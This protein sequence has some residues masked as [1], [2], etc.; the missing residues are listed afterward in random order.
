MKPKNIKIKGTY[1]R[2]MKKITSFLIL[3]IF[4]IAFAPFVNATLPDIASGDCISIKTILNSSSVNI[5]TVSYPNSTMIIINE[6]MTKNAQTFNYSFCNTNE[7]GNYIYDYF[8]NEGNVY[9]NDFNVTSTGES[10]TNLYL[11]LLTCLA[12]I[13]FIASLFVP[14]EFFVYISGVLFLVGGIYLMTNGLNVVNN[15]DTRYLA[16]VYLG[17]GL[18]FTIGAYIY[19]LYSNSSEEEY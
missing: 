19:N 1:K 12:V 5:S 16:Y 18:L 8:D 15:V 10:G 13:F 9:V 3:G 17:I 2:D 6:E 4:I 11:I 14:E 7:L